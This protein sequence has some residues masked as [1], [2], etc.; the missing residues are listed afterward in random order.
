MSNWESRNFSYEV[1]RKFCEC[2]RSF[3]IL[4]VYSLHS[5]PSFT[6]WEKYSGY[7]GSINVTNEIS[8]TII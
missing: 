1:A 6:H 3:G 5:F 4:T 7:M 8:D 2:L